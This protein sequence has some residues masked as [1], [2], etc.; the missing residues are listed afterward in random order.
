MTYSYT[1]GGRT[2]NA[3]LPGGAT[4]ITDKY[5]DGQNKSAT[6]S[7]VVAQY[8]DYGVNADGTRSGQEFTGSA[9]LSSPRW[10]KT[11]IDWLGRNVSIEKPSFTVN[12]LVQ[13]S[14]YNNQGQLQSQS[15]SAGATKLVADKLY[16]Y[17]ELGNQIRG[18]SDIDASGTLTLASTDRI[19]ETDVIY[20]K[21]GSDWFRMTSSR[22]YLVDNN[23]APT[24]QTQTERL[25]N[26]LLNGTSQTASET[27]ATDVAGNSTKTTTAIDRAAR[28]VTTT[29]DI[30]DSDVNAVT[31]A[32][33]GL[34]QSST[35]PTT[36]SATT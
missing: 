31:T 19:T 32:I 23:V 21:T 35:P 3:T 20:Q 16:E 30:S 15:L 7:S 11:T 6:G 14:V 10:T 33:N 8:S 28:K 2:Q 9:G 12:N 29:V 26:F 5:L 4:Q 22:T 27:T 18:G 13:T 36:Q 34:L 24:T 17:D 25:N 1:N